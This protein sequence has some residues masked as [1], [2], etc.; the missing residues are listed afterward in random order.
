MFLNNTLFLLSEPPSPPGR[1][2]PAEISDD[3]ITVYW[4]PPESDGG[5]QI[6]E[7]FVEYR[8]ITVER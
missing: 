4:K 7:Y 8:E 6:V 5:S 3:S 1:P 2:E